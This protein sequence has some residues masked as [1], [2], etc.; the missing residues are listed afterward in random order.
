MQTGLPSKP[1]AN[2]ARLAPGFVPSFSLFSLVI[3]IAATVAWL[4]LV[5]WRVGRH[6]AALWKSLVLPGCG[7]A[8]CWL[9]LMTLWMPLLNYAQSYESMVKRIESQVGVD[10]CVQLREVDL[11]PLAAMRFYG[12]LRLLQGESDLECP[13]LIVDSGSAALSA[14]LTAPTPWQVHDTVRHPVEPFISL[15]LL[16][17]APRA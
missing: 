10:Q 6:R 16:K 5:K 15:T 13:W 7:A 14:V 17:R 12:Q 4:W 2:V 9:L 8:L 11:G 3:A 1:A